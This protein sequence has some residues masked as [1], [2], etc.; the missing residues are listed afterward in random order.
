MDP[1]SFFLLLESWILIRFFQGSDPD[2]FFS[3]VGSLS[4]F[5]GSDPDPGFS[6]VSDAANL[7]PDSQLYAAFRIIKTKI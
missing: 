4:G 2:P 1:D 3:R 5:Q 7:N 6:Q